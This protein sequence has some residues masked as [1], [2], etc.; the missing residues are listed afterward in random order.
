VNFAVGG[1]RNHSSVNICSKGF[2]NSRC[3]YYQAY[4]KHPLSGDNSHIDVKDMTKRENKK[5]G[6]RKR[7]NKRGM[8]QTERAQISVS[9]TSTTLSSAW[10]FSEPAKRKEIWL[11]QRSVDISFRVFYCLVDSENSRE[12]GKVL[13]IKGHVKIETETV[14]GGSVSTPR[15]WEL[16]ISDPV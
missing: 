8:T 5:T 16:P 12:H 3:S 4:T 15:I 1:K 13:Q 2:Q 9:C 6:R 10:G 7:E 11:T 14:Q